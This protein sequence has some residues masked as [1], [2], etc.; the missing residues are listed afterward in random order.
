M[1]FVALRVSI[2]Q[3]CSVFDVGGGESGHWSDRHESDE[4]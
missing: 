3:F 4:S 2:A 1:T